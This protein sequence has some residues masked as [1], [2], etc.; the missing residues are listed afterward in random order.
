MIEQEKLK[1]FFRN[2]IDETEKNHFCTTEELIQFIVGELR[3]L[4]KTTIAIESR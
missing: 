1:E 3:E 2:L 4:E